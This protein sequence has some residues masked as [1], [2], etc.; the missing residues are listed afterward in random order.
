MDTVASVTMTLGDVLM[1]AKHAN[2]YEH[3][4]LLSIQRLWTE[5]KLLLWELPPK[6]L[7]WCR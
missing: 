1:V 4:V 2:S 6:T 3:L 5:Y 7:R